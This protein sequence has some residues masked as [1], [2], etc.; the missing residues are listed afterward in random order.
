MIKKLN[1]EKVVMDDVCLLSLIRNYWIYNFFFKQYKFYDYRFD[2]FFGQ[3]F[4]VDSL[5]NNKVYYIFII[6]GIVFYKIY[7]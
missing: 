1:N 2:Y 4:F 7:L 5:L 3:L 6:D